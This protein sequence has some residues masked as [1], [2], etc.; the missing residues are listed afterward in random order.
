MGQS[1]VSFIRRARFASAIGFLA[2][3]VV[4]GVPRRLEATERFEKIVPADALAFVSV[5]DS[6]AIQSRFRASVYFRIWQEK[7]VQKFLEKPLSQLQVAKDKFRA[8][9]GFSVDD[10]L[11]LPQ[12]QIALALMPKGESGHEK[13]VDAVLL[14][15]VGSNAGK[16]R[17]IVSK[18]T[19]KAVSAGAK[20]TEREFGGEK[21]IVLELPGATK[22]PSAG[23][24]TSASKPAKKAEEG[25]DGLDDE[26]DGES[27]AED[28]G[29]SN[30][31]LKQV[32]FATPGSLFVLGTEP[33]VIEK[34][35]TNL[36][37]H[38]IKSIGDDEDFQ[39][40]T[41]R[42]STGGAG[43]DIVAYVPLGSILDRASLSKD[44][45]QGLAL[46]GLRAVRTLAYG[47]GLEP[48]VVK[49]NLFA[50]TRGE[51]KGLLR[52]LSTRGSALQ[53]PRV[54][55][56]DVVAAGIASIDWLGFLG[57]IESA[58]QATT[59]E[60][61]AEWQGFLQQTKSKTGLDLKADLLGNLTGDVSLFTKPPTAG[62]SPIPIT[63]FVVLIG[64]KS[65]ERMEQA[66]G[67]LAALSPQPL[68]TK[69]DYNGVSINEFNMGGGA[70]G[71]MPT[72]A[73]AI[74]DEHL[75]ISVNASG[76]EDVLRRVGKDVPSLIDNARYK[77]AFAG[78]PANRSAL[79]FGDDAKSVE[80][81]LDSF[82]SIFYM[83]GGMGEASNWIDFALLPQGSTIAK[84]LGYSG[85]EVVH[86][87]D[88]ILVTSNAFSK[89]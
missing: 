88:G 29:P 80:T 38:S 50:G 53:V 39:R 2:W 69:R 19:E 1:S 65:K 62:A 68:F 37:G 48:D 66:I 55:P 8:E 81:S 89:K 26:A 67:K 23:E 14:V 3:V 24:T 70:G 16:L 27:A 11:E 47:V 44:D 10:L 59:P 49:W 64:H 5:T 21:I 54:T 83:L 28:A 33:T 18:A 60:G 57:D 15:D 63:P 61:Y 41:R 13:D 52:L 72:P 73:Y 34:V 79:M 56:D 77:A 6:V 9:F 35:L 86:E 75:L 30:L 36:K 51:K 84:H 42:I 4:A 40:A 22:S 20:R 45:E 43:A 58:L 7:E 85:L 71:G 25:D 82:R 46:F 76:I 32:V 17:D 78:L 12:G 74:T 87:D 31:G